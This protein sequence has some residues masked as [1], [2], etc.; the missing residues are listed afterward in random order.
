[1]HPAL[2]GELMRR[3]CAPAAVVCLV[4]LA[5][6]Q[7]GLQPLGDSAPQGTVASA[8]P[9]Y[10]CC[11]I[12]TESDWLSDGGYLVGR[13]I[14]AGTLVKLTGT[15]RGVANV[16]IDDR[17][18]RL[19][20][21]FGARAEALDN[22]LQKVLVDKDPSAKIASYPKP[23]RDAIKSGK[24]ARGMSKEQVIVALGYPPAHANSTL[25]ASDWTY[26]Y[27]RWG[28]YIVQFNDAGRVR[29]VNAIGGWRE[30]VLAR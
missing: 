21:E 18:Y 5:G 11:N 16:E 3:I 14:P 24:I 29:D 25:D 22:W 17:R 7:A 26:M 15:R 20:N 27:N 2:N 9:L 19:S 23:V 30:T 4:G 12:R 10:L 6:C 1:M 8:K 13:I 28:R